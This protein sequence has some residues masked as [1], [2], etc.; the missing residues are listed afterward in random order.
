MFAAADALLKMNAIDMPTFIET[1]NIQTEQFSDEALLSLI[2]NPTLLRLQEI[3]PLR[4][5]AFHVT[6]FS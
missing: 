4:G 2:E 5:T 6:H 1:R 3:I